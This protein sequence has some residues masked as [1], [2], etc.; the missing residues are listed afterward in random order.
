LATVGIALGNAWLAQVVPC[1]EEIEERA[2]KAAGLQQIRR[3]NPIGER[4]LC[5]E[6]PE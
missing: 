2:V 5:Q 6:E 4:P 3:R 1:L